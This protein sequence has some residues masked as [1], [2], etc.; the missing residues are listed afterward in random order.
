MPKERNRV[1]ISIIIL[2]IACSFSQIP[3]QEISG[4]L[5][6]SNSYYVDDLGQFIEY[7]DESIVV[8]DLPDIITNV[9]F[10]P[11][12]PEVIIC[13]GQSYIENYVAVYNMISWK[14]I[15]RISMMDDEI[16]LSATCEITM[17]PDGSFFLR[18]LGGGTFDV[19]STT[20]YSI[21]ASL[22]YNENVE[23][24]GLLLRGPDMIHIDSA[25]DYIYFMET[26]YNTIQKWA[27]STW[28][29][30]DELYVDRGLENRY[31]F[32]WADDDSMFAV[33][34]DCGFEVYSAPYF[35]LLHF[36]KLDEEGIWGDCYDSWLVGVLR[37]VDN[38]NYLLRLHDNNIN[39]H[40][41]TTW[42]YGYWDIEVFDPEGS[43][44]WFPDR[45][46]VKLNSNSSINTQMILIEDY[47]DLLKQNNFSTLPDAESYT[48]V[49]VGDRT[50]YDNFVQY[51]GE[52]TIYTTSFNRLYKWKLKT[53]WDRDLDNVVNEEDNCPGTMNTNQSNYDGDENG[54]LCDVDDDG[55]GIEDR[56]DNCQF[57]LLNWKSDGKIDYD[58]DGCLDA[59]EDRDDDG[60]GV[61]DETD[62]CPYDADYSVTPAEGCIDKRN[63]VI[64]EEPNSPPPSDS[65]IVV[66]NAA[67]YAEGLVQMAY[68]SAGLNVILIFTTIMLWSSKR[69]LKRGT[70]S[71][72]TQPSF[73]TAPLPPLPSRIVTI[74]NAPL[75]AA[76]APPNQQPPRH[77]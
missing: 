26:S 9:Y 77:P 32:S 59:T 54:D 31:L 10:I 11:N 52:E 42:N 53:G 46:V 12:K 25:G 37:F 51:I 74:P 49:R 61:W 64:I 58:Q 8:G 30:A 20:D 55:D 1:A 6:T 71:N 17:S 65:E 14:E 3:S 21:I 33:E 28:S 5:P 38:D 41:T 76:P 35:Q 15:N 4:D 73:P 75:P 67:A 22:D 69:K 48:V 70:V 13:V 44:Y 50:G 68:G 23:N 60:D 24:E 19:Y 27:V 40:S 56:Y 36:E 62:G 18:S 39:L 43:R 66:D 16:G 34:V 57:G 45:V 2:L 7:W 29:L 63:T 47:V 72:L